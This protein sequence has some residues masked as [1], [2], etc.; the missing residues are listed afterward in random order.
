MLTAQSDSVNMTTLNGL[1]TDQGV[2]LTWTTQGE[3]NVQYFRIERS[4]DAINF[5]TITDMPS[6]GDGI[7]VKRYAYKDNN[8]FRKHVYYRITTQFSTSSKES[9]VVAVARNN[10]LDLPDIMI[11]PTIT[12][13]YVNIVKNSPDDLSGAYIRVFDLSGHLLVDKLIGGDF[14]VETVDVSGYDAGA[15]VVE[16][17]KDQLAVKAKI[18]KQY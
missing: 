15:Y 17:Y 7:E 4:L 18:I 5:E 14:L 1:A 16:L 2:E 11:Y 8:V 6:E 10:R 9:R 13:Q 3:H 12:S